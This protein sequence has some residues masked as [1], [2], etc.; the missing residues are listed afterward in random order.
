MSENSLEKR[1]H[2]LEMGVM[3]LITATVGV[4]AY[5]LGAYHTERRVLENVR[6]SLDEPDISLETEWFTIS[7]G[8]CR[9][10]VER[11]LK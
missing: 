4:G 11:S 1:L 10:I 8:D 5:H 7:Y 2:A 3:L 6:Y 9:S